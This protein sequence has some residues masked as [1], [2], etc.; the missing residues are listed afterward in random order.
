MTEREVGLDPPLERRHAE[1]L[2][3][4]ALMPGERLRKLGECGP[5]PECERVTE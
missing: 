5:A 3:T 1:L 4:R 2:E